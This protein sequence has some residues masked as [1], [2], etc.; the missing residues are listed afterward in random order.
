MLR[1]GTP[2]VSLL[3]ALVAVVLVQSLSP[4]A[5]RL[6]TG[7]ARF[8]LA[9]G[10][11]ATSAGGLH[12]YG[13]WFTTPVIGWLQLG[14]LDRLLLGGDA[15]TV[16][17]AAHGGMLLTT[18][19][20]VALLWFVLRRAGAS[21]LAAGAST[22]A[23]GIAPV[24]IAVHTQVVPVNVALVWLLIAALLVLGR[25]GI[26]GSVA[27][28]AL[29]ATAVLTAPIALIALP[30]L[31]WAYLL[32]HD[33]RERTLLRAVGAPPVQP[34]RRPA[35]GALAGFLVVL[36]IGLLAGLL[37]A[38]SGGAA[39]SADAIGAAAAGQAAFPA[40]GAASAVAWL[41]ADPLSLLLGLV[42]V[43]LT[44][45]SW[46]MAPVTL[47][48][49]LTAIVAFWPDGQ[50]PVGPIVLL[51]PVFTLA[52]AVVIDRA[53]VALGDPRFAVSAIGSGWLMGVLALIVVAV[54]V[55]VGALPALQPGARQP[56]VRAEGWV[57]RSVPAGQ[58][59]LVDLGTWP[60]LVTGTRARV[61]WFAPA[62][63]APAPS[64][65]PWSTADYLVTTGPELAASTGA[66]QAV[67]ARSLPVARFGVG[68]G[69]VA[70]RAVRSTP[71]PTPSATPPTAAE[72]RAAD[73]RK[74]TGA[75]LAQNPRLTVDGP[76]RALLQGGEVDSRIAIVL[77]QLLSQHTVTIGGFPALA[78]DT[79]TVRRQAV[80]SAIDGRPVPADADATGTVLRYLSSLRGDYATSTIDATDAGVLATFA[81][82]PTFVPSP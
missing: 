42:A 49:A 55:W 29:A 2:L 9:G 71:A 80:I 50:D 74:R 58:V 13:H 60:D 35:I 34:S 28:G 51:L 32:P 27:I 38:R 33:R 22:A 48:A 17:A 76:D 47:L 14:A 30:G 25:R 68:A 78:G 53:V 10:W 73:A 62:E 65:A 1:S 52:T 3:P 4:A 66:S 36:A 6:P 72:R 37:V 63:D 59:V 41:R 15:Q 67:L 69:A 21:G 81:P 61:G 79:G 44:P 18:L 20:G 11:A 56:V 54:V 23:F 5:Q 16:L 46:S 12:G 19:A 39:G 75:E 70:V 40:L 64:S 8:A 77:G 26:G 43:V 57:R 45:R 82:D 24:A 7:D 31:V